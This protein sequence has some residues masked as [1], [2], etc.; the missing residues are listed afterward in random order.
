MRTYT[1]QEQAKH[2]HLQAILDLAAVSEGK[3][4]GTYTASA[5]DW[6]FAPKSAASAAQ[7]TPAKSGFE[8]WLTAEEKRALRA[9]F[10][11]KQR[12][13]AAC[14]TEALDYMLCSKATGVP[15]SRMSERVQAVYVR[16]AK[17]GQF[18]ILA[19][20]IDAG[21]LDEALSPS[22]KDTIRRICTTAIREG[23][24]LRAREAKRKASSDQLA[25]SRRKG[26]K[27]A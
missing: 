9:Y 14:G 10:P 25:K 19:E 1:E 5:L 17:R 16:T 7:P 13:N 4:L 23:R 26:A 24:E 11:L 21:E 20:A 12:R 22:R 2:D 8:D 3:P 6:Y 15:I 27:A 18:D